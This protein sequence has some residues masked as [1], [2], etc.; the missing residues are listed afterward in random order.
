MRASLYIFAPFE[1]RALEW[2]AKAELLDC[3]KH[4]RHSCNY[5]VSEIRVR[6]KVPQK[7]LII[8][9]DSQDF[10]QSWENMR[11]EFPGNSRQRHKMTLVLHLWKHQSRT[12]RFDVYTW[13][14]TARK[15]STG[16]ELNISS[17]KF[18]TLYGQSAVK[19][20]ERSWREGGVRLATVEV[21]E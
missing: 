1:I 17:T 7:N 9:F 2:R 15:S 14:K 5:V 10:K 6:F 19:K 18:Y 3:R 4:F 21:L 16:K 12:N 8:R 11:A 13:A 20:K